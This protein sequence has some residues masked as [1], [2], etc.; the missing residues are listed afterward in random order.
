MSV[1]GAQPPLEVNQSLLKWSTLVAT[2]V[3]TVAS[4]VFNDKSSP[5]STIMKSDVLF[6]IGCFLNM[7]EV[8]PS[9]QALGQTVMALGSGIA[10]VTIPL[11][12]AEELPTP[13][14]D[15]IITLSGLLQAVGPTFQ[16]VLILKSKQVCAFPFP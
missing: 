13:L 9:V 14:Q 12:I 6:A 7:V 8:V 16:Y 3:G 11:F 5:R 2:L 1:L 10:I 15:R 4:C